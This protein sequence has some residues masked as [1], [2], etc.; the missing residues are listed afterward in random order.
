MKRA[1]QCIDFAAQMI[2][3]SRKLT[4]PAKYLK[5]I[6]SDSPEDIPDDKE[7]PVKG[8]GKLLVTDIINESLGDAGINLQLNWG[9]KEPTL[10]LA[11]AGLFGALGVQLLSTVTNRNIAICSGCNLLY[12]RQGRKPQAGRRNFCMTCRDEVA[13]RLRQRDRRSKMKNEVAAN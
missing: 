6:A 13:N 4:V 9:S 12:L 11:G 1:I 5:R 2:V 10:I 8:L 3:D 7:V